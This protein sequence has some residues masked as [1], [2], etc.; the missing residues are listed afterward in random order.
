MDRSQ[1]RV[2]F[3]RVKNDLGF[4]PARGG[5]KLVE[6]QSLEDLVWRVRE[7]GWIQ[8]SSGDDGLELLRY[9]RHVYGFNFFIGFNVYGC[10][11]MD[12]HK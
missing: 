8:L 10:R 9:A 1:S 12:E 7:E 2:C 6:K 11:V 5:V 3:C 4:E